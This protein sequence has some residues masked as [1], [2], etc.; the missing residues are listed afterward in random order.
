MYIIIQYI[1]LNFLEVWE[2]VCTIYL[3]P[4]V[5][6]LMDL[7]QNHRQRVLVLPQTYYRISLL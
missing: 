3:S 2:T 4:H 6:N 7:S 5:S 1:I